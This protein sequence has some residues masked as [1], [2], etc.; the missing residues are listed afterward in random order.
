LQDNVEA[1]LYVFCYLAERVDEFKY[2]LGSDC[3]IVSQDDF[4]ARE[5]MPQKQVN[6]LEK[7]PTLRVL[8]N[9]TLVSA[10]VCAVQVVWSFIS[11][12]LLLPTVAAIVFLLIISHGW[13]NAR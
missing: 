10:V 4:V 2:P 9:T 13:L 11:E 3:F 7:E 8:S 6:H 1:G 12:L 5:H